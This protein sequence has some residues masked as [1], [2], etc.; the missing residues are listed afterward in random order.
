MWVPRIQKSG[1]LTADISFRVRGCRSSLSLHALR[2]FMLIFHKSLGGLFPSLS[3]MPPSSSPL[4]CIDELELCGQ[5]V[6]RVT[7]GWES[8]RV[9]RSP[10]SECPL[11]LPAWP[12]FGQCRTE[13]AGAV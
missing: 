4:S 13:V 9:P 1:D 11:V 2:V 10:V 7:P 6:V 12:I 5:C 3:H 8:S